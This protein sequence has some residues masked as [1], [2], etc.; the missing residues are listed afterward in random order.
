MKSNILNF[1]CINPGYLGIW[2]QHVVSRII[3]RIILWH[4]IRR[5][6]IRFW[7]WTR[8]WRCFWWCFIGRR[9]TQCNVFQKATKGVVNM[10][11]WMVMTWKILLIIDLYLWAGPAF[12]ITISTIVLSQIKL[13]ILVVRRYIGIRS[14]SNIYIT[15]LIYQSL[16]RCCLLYLH[17]F[18]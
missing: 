14:Q 6:W 10:M 7:R 1:F 12:I 13:I 16:L 5:F 2:L 3:R 17:C 9:S 4:I 18:C 8:F 15:Y 11:E